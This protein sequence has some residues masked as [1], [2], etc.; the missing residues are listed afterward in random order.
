ML[1]A[2]VFSKG[3]SMKTRQM[4]IAFAM[5]TSAAL[6]VTGCSGGSGPD[7]NASGPDFNG[8]IT[9][10]MTA[11]GFTLGDEVAT[12]RADYAAAQ[13]K[14]DGATVTINQGNFDSQKFAAQ[15]A[16]GNL[17]DLVLMDRQYVATYASKGLIVPLDKCYAAQ[18][19]KPE[20]HY[21]ASLLDDVKYDGDIYGV[22][23]FWQPQA[24]LLNTRVMDAA[25]VTAD[26]FDTSQPDKIL[27][28]T[29]KMYKESNGN[30]TTLGFDAQLPGSA[31]M[32]FLAFGGKVMDKNGKPALDDPNNIKALEW[33]KSV[34]AAQGGYEK[35][36]S[37]GQTWDF[38]GAKN[39]FVSDQVGA[40]L[41][42]Q[43]YPNVLADFA[44]DT[45]LSG[46]P[47][48][49]PDGKPIAAAGGSAYVIPAKAKNP[50]AACKWAIADTS[51]EAWTAAVEARLET[52]KKT[53]GKLFTGLFTGSSTADKIIK[54]QYLK[55]TGNKGFDEAI[56]AYYEG[57]SNPASLGSSP[58]GLQ[59]NTELQNAIVPAMTDK[60]TVKEA[61]GDA[62]AAAL[63]AYNQAIKK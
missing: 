30:P 4:T 33:L 23:Q 25:G 53:P 19:V 21:Y 34:Y 14:K 48:R 22:P 1:S 60:K 24:I 12:S 40:G 49:G 32:W 43:W 51:D 55:P 29:K 27:E 10:S 54:D 63:L 13:L 16:S 59:I 36:Y 44:K 56:N 61:L 45:T 37:F 3:T 20:D 15:A 62:Q 57:L 7:Q 39:Q 8:K 46:V 38:F 28:A 31:N 2:G 50:A 58:A 35:A 42:A 11:G 26:D 52:V 9:G 6:L 41:Y 18:D 17:P 47:M 5:A